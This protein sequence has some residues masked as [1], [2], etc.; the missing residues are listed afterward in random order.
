[1]YSTAQT[2]QN[3]GKKITLPIFC[4]RTK[5]SSVRVLYDVWVEGEYCHVP[6]KELGRE[7]EDAWL[8]PAEDTWEERQ[9]LR[10]KTRT[11]SL[12]R[13]VLEEAGLSCQNT[14]PVDPIVGYPIVLTNVEL[15]N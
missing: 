9:R 7:T 1:M 4:L 6:E 13:L 12:R 8:R 11:E 15:N 10:Q 14:K 3:L 5:T 2:S